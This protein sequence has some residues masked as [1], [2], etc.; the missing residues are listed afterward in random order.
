MMQRI[1]RLVTTND[2]GLRIGESHARA[3][4]TDHEVD[5]IRELHEEHGMGYRL[6]ATKFEV[7]KRT[8]RDICSYRKRAQT[9]ANVKVIIIESE[10]ALV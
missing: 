2:R 7:S 5:L 6:L 8:I 4:L 9:V 1:I 10:G 3:K